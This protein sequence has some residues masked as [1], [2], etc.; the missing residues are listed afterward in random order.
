MSDRLLRVP[1]LC[2]TLGL[3]RSS[4]YDMIERKMLPK[5]IKLA[6]VR[7]AAWVESEIQA[8]VR[9]II[10]GKSDAEM[11]E[12]VEELTARRKQVQQQVAA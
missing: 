9:A 7:R 1:D 12:L 4:V 5:P 11:R 10:A 3:C 6:G 2:G 8:C